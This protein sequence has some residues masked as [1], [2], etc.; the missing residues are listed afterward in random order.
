MIKLIVFDL[1][2]TL[3]HEGFALEKVGEGIIC[4]ETVKVLDYLKSKGYKMAIASHNHR[5]KYY[6]EYLKLIQYFDYI[7]GKDGN[8]KLEH[9]NG[10]LTESNIPYENWF[11]F[12]DLQINIDHAQKLGIKGKLVDWKNGITMSDLDGL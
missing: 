10:I 4:G 3:I 11:F 12:D 9:F 8:D 1:D 7:Y 6:L 2:D 5:A